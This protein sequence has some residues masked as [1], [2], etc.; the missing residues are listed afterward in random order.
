MSEPLTKGE[1]ARA[2]TLR[3]RFQRPV[4]SADDCLE[5]RA[6]ARA[7]LGDWDAIHYLYVRYH[8]DVRAYVLSI[9]GDHHDAEDITQSLFARLTRAIR[10]YEPRDVAFIGWLLRV[11]RNA[12]LDHLRAKRQIPVEGVRLDQDE[13]AQADFDRSRLLR[14]AFGQLPKDQRTV[15]MLRHIAGLSPPE[16]AQRLNKSEGSIHGLHHRGRKAL[17]KTIRQMELAPAGARG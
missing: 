7:K 11:A 4:Q 12:A 3:R 15:L 2:H 1:Q 10:K 9:V 13:N 6:I 14:D 5:T 8:A 16:I 17:Q